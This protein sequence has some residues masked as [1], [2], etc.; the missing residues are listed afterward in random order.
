LRG[1]VLESQNYNL[2]EYEKLIQG[3]AEPPKALKS[4][5][6]CKDREGSYF[7]MA[8]E[9]NDSESALTRDNVK[10]IESHI[11]ML[12]KEIEKILGMNYSH[13]ERY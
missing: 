12:Y 13:T 9:P 4:A 2:Y 10:I 3:V 7:Y 8:L 5:C 6:I 11:S 1:S